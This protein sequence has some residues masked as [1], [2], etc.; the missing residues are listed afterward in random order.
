M[1]TYLSRSNPKLKFLQQAPTATA[2]PAS[3]GAWW[4]FLC[5]GEASSG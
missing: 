1:Y 3:V 4:S 5:G 2:V